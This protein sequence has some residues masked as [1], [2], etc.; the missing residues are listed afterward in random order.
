MPGSAISFRDLAD[1]GLELTVY[2]LLLCFAQ[3]VVCPTPSERTEDDCESSEDQ[4]RDNEEHR[5]WGP[6]DS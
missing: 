4:E 6:I 5:G 3:S 1:D 2:S